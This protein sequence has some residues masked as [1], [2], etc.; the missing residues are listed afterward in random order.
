[1]ALPEP[2]A[3]AAGPTPGSDGRPADQ[4]HGWREPRVRR[5]LQAAVSILV[6]GAIFWFVLGQFATCPRCGARFAR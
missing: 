5:A 2:D 4:P 3:P 6:V 1:M